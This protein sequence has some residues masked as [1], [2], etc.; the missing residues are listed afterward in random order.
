MLPSLAD[1]AEIFAATFGFALL[2]GLIPFLN[3]E[4]Y[5]LSVSALLPDAPLLPV[6]VAASAGQM[7]A[8]SLLY[9]VA[10]GALRPPAER[11]EDGM[12]RL[13]A[14]L[15]RGTGRATA[16]VFV[17]AVVGLPPFY[18]VSLAAGLL[19]FR[20]DCFLAAGSSGRLLRFAA[21]FV[22]PRLMTLPA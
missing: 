12:Q 19:R 21:V 16:L 7:T 14:S 18:A 5:L 13:A 17:S 4:A 1:A 3:V 20:L 10:R 22:L 9:L 2:S 8:K 6:V 15:A 11:C